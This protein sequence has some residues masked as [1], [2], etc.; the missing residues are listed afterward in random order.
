[1]SNPTPNGTQTSPTP[2]STPT[3]PSV[4][5]DVYG[6]GSVTK[7][8]EIDWGIIFVDK[9]STYNISVTN[10]GDVPVILDLL[11]TNWSQGVYGVITWDYN[12]SAIPVYESVDITLSL[13]INY[14][15]TT[16]FSNDIIITSRS[17]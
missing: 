5:I 12:G 13:K 16:T 11:V 3:P 15:T 4:N 17:T 9:T 8:E 10:A 14:A 6:K 7:L 1:M 2:T